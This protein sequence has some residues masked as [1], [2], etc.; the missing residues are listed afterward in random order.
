M[1]S[2]QCLKKWFN[3]MNDQFPQFGFKYKYFSQ[4]QTHYIAVY[5]YS[6]IEQ[7]LMYCKEEVDFYGF[8]TH[9]FPDETFLFGSEMVNFRPL[10]NPEI[11]ENKATAVNHPPINYSYNLVL[12]NN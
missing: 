2:S 7:D 5:P 6:M 8:L 1:N 9:K 10:E 12:E 4:D 11:F 3:S